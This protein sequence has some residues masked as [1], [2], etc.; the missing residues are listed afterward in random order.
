MIGGRVPWETIEGMFTR[1]GFSAA[2]LAFGL[3]TQTEAGVV[4]SGY[5]RAE[6]NGSPSFIFYHPI[7]RYREILLRH[8]PDPS[9][10]AEAND[11]DIDPSTRD[12]ALLNA[13]LESCRISAA[14]ALSR[15]EK[16][17][18]VCH[19]VYAVGGTPAAPGAPE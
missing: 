16:G 11:R 17:E 12:V 10:S 2:I 1:A 5:A 4:L 19:S 7:E 3:K 14:T 6:R 15:H 18:A 9:D 8:S 13:A